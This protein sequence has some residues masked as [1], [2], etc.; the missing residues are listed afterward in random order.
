MFILELKSLVLAPLRIN[1][2]EIGPRVQIFQ[3]DSGRVPI[4][5]IHPST[6]LLK[7]LFF[8]LTEAERPKSKFESKNEGFVA[9]HCEITRKSRVELGVGAGGWNWDVNARKLSISQIG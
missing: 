2:R 4:T 6:L 5:S 3:T 7:T 8:F 9:L 1:G